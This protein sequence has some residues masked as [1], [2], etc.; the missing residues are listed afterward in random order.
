MSK[1]NE[2]WKQKVALF[3]KRFTAREDAFT[4]RFTY[5][6]TVIDESTQEPRIEQVSSFQL[7]CQNYGNKD[8]CLITQRKGG[9]RSCSNKVNQPLTD[10]W[11]WKHISGEN[12]L[13]L[14]ML[15]QEG[16]KFGAADFDTGQVFEDAKAVRNLSVS[17]GIP[18]YIARSS[19]KGYHVY[20][21]FDKFVEPHLFTSFIRYLFD[22]LGFY[23]RMEVI[24]GVM[25]NR[26]PEVF[27][28]QTQFNNQAIGNGI[29]VPMIEPKM[30]E[31]WNCWVDDNAK[32]IPI[33]QQWKYFE[34]L[35]E[36]DTEKFRAALE[37][38]KVPI[39]KAPASR[40]T[41]EAQQAESNGGVAT[42][43]KPF[44]SFMGVIEGCPAMREYWTKDAS[45]A[46]IWDKSN[47]KGLFHNAR[48]A[49]LFIGASTTDGL[50]I[51]KQRWPS[52]NTKYNIEHALQKGYKP[53][54]CRWLQEMGVCH[55]GKHPRHLD[56][57]MKKM[58]P[59][60]RISGQDIVNPNNLPESQWKE[61]SPI[62]YATDKHLTADDIIERLGIL[63]AS[64]T[65][66]EGDP[67][68][69]VKLNEAGQPV[70]SADYLAD[71]LEER[72]AS[73]L[74]RVTSLPKLD[75]S[76]I[77]DV[78]KA[79]KWMKAKD[80]NTIEKQVAKE[81]QNERVEVKRTQCKS[82]RYNSAEYFM[83][84][85]KYL[86]MKTDAKGNVHEEELS[87]F[88][89]ELY[90][91]RSLFKLRNEEE[92]MNLS[93]TVQDRHVSGAVVISGK[94]YPFQ[95]PISAW[96]GGVDKWYETLV[97]IAGT[98][99]L[100]R[101][102]NLEDLRLCVSMFNRDTKVERKMSRAI[103]HHN[104]GG[105]T[106]YM[107][108]S[109]IVDKETIRPNTEYI[110]EF[111][112]DLCKG[113]DFKIISDD[114]LKNL[115]S[116]IISDYFNCNNR[117]ITM[118]IFAQAMAAPLATKIPSF[119]KSPV[120][121]V[122]GNQSGGK[123][124]VAESAQFFYG[125]FEIL[126]GAAGSS[127]SRLNAASNF[128]HAFMVVD[129]YKQALQDPTGRDFSQFIQMAYDRSARPVLQRSGVMRAQLDR[130]RG[131]IAITGEDFPHQEASTITRMLLVETKLTPNT[132]AGARV[133]ATRQ[134]YRGF[135]PY[136][137]QFLYNLD[138]SEVTKM[139]SEY[140]DKFAKP[141]VEVGKAINAHR[142]CENLALN[143]VA[144]RLVME[145][146]VSKGAIPDVMRD[147]LCV[148]HFKN[149]EHV[150][151]TV[152]DR[153][154][155]VRGS[156]N[157]ITELNA[158]LQNQT[159]FHIHNYNGA[160][161]FTDG[162]RNSMALG[163]Y[164]PE[165]PDVVW[166]FAKPAYTEVSNQVRKANEYL[167]AYNQVSRQLA[168]D[169]YIREGIADRGRHTKRISGIVG[170]TQV[171]AWPIKIEAFKTIPVDKESTSKSEKSAV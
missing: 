167:Q 1:S 164:K 104:I 146:M 162:M 127:K 168:D 151:R 140:R 148:E 133:I 78:I 56:H 64:K 80:L 109:V 23:E 97:K 101:R 11:I 87:N 136:F 156:V 16:I 128:R 89:V 63:F 170:Q 160:S 152:I 144:F 163:V 150:R 120:L 129:D 38:H 79:N 2:I 69:E 94:K 20:W 108:P 24:N 70:V 55:A 100:V 34:S 19:K 116:H 98:D 68:A 52:T 61:P 132:N 154:T 46:Y 28:K 161:S 15:R 158:L 45:G 6:T 9:C 17:M 134:Q 10:E 93:Q 18:C 126:Q 92:D 125:N 71:N 65:K 153:S 43:L 25:M 82:F 139:W 122:S 88:V 76:R 155:D 49:S 60:E 105:N 110:I 166:I 107:M 165:T 40:S 67:G 5:T 75:Q 35:S 118:S 81:I 85:G 123:T 3:R 135:T 57:C 131:L 41:Q 157:F 31:G 111:E 141:L 26:V 44:G 121:W 117:M 99:L 112:D 95:E 22:S 119:K 36:V 8:L 114:E 77:H 42:P 103:G 59:V 29:K 91:E 47:P 62:R 147:Q 171:I 54:T 159:K 115:C 21:F 39:L 50:E 130:V 138:N 124:F 84:D 169:G 33:E 83:E 27:P 32:P 74:R 37:L 143:M 96:S 149:L 137:I 113:L 72:L 53:P 7:Q 73:L 142:V 58:P 106:I 14:I 145:M 30:R 66:K 4:S 51:I 12:D 13:V 48:L 86:V 90:E 102:S